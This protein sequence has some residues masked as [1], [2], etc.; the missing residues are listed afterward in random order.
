MSDNLPAAPETSFQFFV[1]EDGRTKI[2]VRFEGESVWLSQKALAEL[3]G[4]DVRTINEHIQNIFEENELAPEATIR[5]FRIVQNEGSRQ[6][7]R[8][9][10]IA[11]KSP[12][13]KEKSHEQVA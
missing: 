3:F 10:W 6:D 11:C 1:A 5:N 7:L 9:L 4:K 12:A 2:S 13:S 8:P